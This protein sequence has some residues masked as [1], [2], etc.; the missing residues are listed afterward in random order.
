MQRAG[1]L[2]HKTAGVASLGAP[3]KKPF[4]GW[5]YL[6]TLK[7]SINVR[8]PHWRQ[9]LPLQSLDWGG[10]DQVGG[11]P[12]LWPWSRGWEWRRF[13]LSQSG[14]TTPPLMLRNNLYGESQTKLNIWN[15]TNAIFANIN[16]GYSPVTHHSPWLKSFSSVE[17]WRSGSSQNC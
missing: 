3:I 9:D 15:T 6:K 17:T 5:K 12:V 11:S 16:T 10:D 14:V 13:W 8:A 7:L 1:S 2:K 4:S